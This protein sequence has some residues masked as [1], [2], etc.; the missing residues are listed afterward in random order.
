M[1]HYGLCGPGGGRMKGAQRLR[2]NKRTEANLLSPE[3]LGKGQTPLGEGEVT[4]QV[5]GRPLSLTASG[6][7]C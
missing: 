1:A 4:W 7:S 6:V 3:A 2:V 5:P